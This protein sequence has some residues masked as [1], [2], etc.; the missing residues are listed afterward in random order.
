MLSFN[1]KR[2]NVVEIESPFSAKEKGQLLQYIPKILS[3]EVVKDL[4]PNFQGVNTSE[5]GEIWLDDMCTQSRVLVIYNKQLLPIGFLFIAAEKGANHL[6]YLFDENYW[7]AGLASELLREFIVQVRVV[8]NWQKLIAGVARD[9]VASIR[10]LK[11][12]G[13]KQGK[14]TQGDTLLYEIELR[15]RTPC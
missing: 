3:P 12:V 13:F 2:L 9:N 6:G 4:P 5:A 15:S 11:K 1:T 10:V 14:Q 7:G 8:T